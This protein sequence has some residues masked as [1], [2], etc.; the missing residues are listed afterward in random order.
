MYME[1]REMGPAA[2]PR[3]AG[4]GKLAV[5]IATVG[6]AGVLRRTLDAIRT[7]TRP[8]DRIVVCAPQP[9]DVAGL[10]DYPDVTLIVGPRG[11]PIQR[12]AIFDAVTDCD[13]IVFFDDDFVPQAAYLARTEYVFRA[14]PDVVMTTGHVLRD[15]INGPGLPFEVAEQLIGAVADLPQADLARLEE[16]YNSYGCNMGVNLVVA[17]Q[18][19][20]YFDPELPLYAWWEDVDFSRRMAPYGRI[21]RIHQAQGV[22]LG[23][24]SGRQSGVRLGSSQIANPVYLSRK[25]TC[26]PFRAAGQ[27][28]RNVLANLAKALWPER[29]VDRRGRVRGNIRAIADLFSGRLR[30]GRV[31]DF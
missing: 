19:A 4:S 11:L 15:G 25:G 24:K 7:Q 26:S 28:M 13:R 27:I 1:F 14:L 23:T 2:G 12:N 20:L 8:P 3:M 31:L 9:T 5:G 10:E 21:V 30:P 29:Y 22:H 16:V 17:R 18:Q 6:R